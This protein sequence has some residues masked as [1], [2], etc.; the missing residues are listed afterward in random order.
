MLSIVTIELAGCGSNGDTS[1]G[2]TSTEQKS[3]KEYKK[4]EEALGEKGIDYDY[5]EMKF[6]FDREIN[7][8]SQ[9]NLQ[10]KGN[11]DGKMKDTLCYDVSE[12]KIV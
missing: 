10:L 3:A 12:G 9:V 7:E 5:F 1:S 2:K 6:Q 8:V 4:M 11:S